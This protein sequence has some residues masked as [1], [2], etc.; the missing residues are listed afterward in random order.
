M[1]LEIQLGN[2]SFTNEMLT[3]TY[4]DYKE[5]LTAVQTKEVMLLKELLC[6][7]VGLQ[8]GEEHEVDSAAALPKLLLKAHSKTSILH[9]RFAKHQLKPANFTLCSKAKVPKIFNHAW[10]VFGRLVS[11]SLVWTSQ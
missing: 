4:L 5:Y 10:V 11:Q 1:V 2:F 8:A 9:A 3:T 7:G 6:L